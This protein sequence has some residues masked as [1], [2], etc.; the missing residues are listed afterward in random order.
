M[1]VFSVFIIF[2]ILVVLFQHHLRKNMRI[3]EEAKEKFWQKEKSS[4]IVR[5]K[6]FT[7]SDYIKIP[8]DQVTFDL[9]PSFE[10]GDLMYYR[11]LIRKLHQLEKLDM[12]NFSHLS[13]TEVRLQFG[14][15]NQTII[16]N[17]ESN[18]NNYLQVLGKLAKLFA[19]NN[20]HTM[21]I[22][23]LERCI[24]MKSDYRDHFILLGHLYSNSGNYVAIKE[25]IK[26]AEALNS[27]LKKGLITSLKSL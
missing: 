19:D 13:N 5:K 18:Y 15:A 22:K 26:Q 24:A 25:L 4:L 23:I 2:I 1:A 16:Q 9:E 3:E 6:E 8:K 7:E 17:N 27:P 12:M 20:E 14:T 11:Q 10:K 21:A